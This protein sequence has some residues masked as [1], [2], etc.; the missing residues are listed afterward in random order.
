MNWVFFINIKKEMIYEINIMEIFFKYWKLI[1]FI[2]FIML[3][4]IIKFLFVCDYIWKYESCI[5]MLNEM[6]KFEDKY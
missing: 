4:F 3:D 5:D 1:S 6:F 2:S